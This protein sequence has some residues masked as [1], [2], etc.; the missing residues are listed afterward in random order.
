MQYNVIYYIVNYFVLL[1]T[2]ISWTEEIRKGSSGAV[3]V[4]LFDEE[5]YAHLRKAQRDGANL[6]KVKSMLDITINTI[7][8][9]KGPWVRAEL[10][11]ALFGSILAYYA[12]TTK[13]K[14]QA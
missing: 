3:I 8:A 14:V 5:G 9:Y 12:L 4:R 1:P 11:A 13:S 10:V 7:G 6:S 2:Q